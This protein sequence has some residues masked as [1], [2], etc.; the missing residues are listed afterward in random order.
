MN[1]ICDENASAMKIRQ[2]PKTFSESEFA[3]LSSSSRKQN[4]S[5]EFDFTV[6][7]AGKK[8]SSLQAGGPA[9]VI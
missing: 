8:R 5:F 4:S 9:R 6:L 3:R 2:E 7:P 1:P